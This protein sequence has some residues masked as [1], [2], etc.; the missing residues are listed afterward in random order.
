MCTVLWA[1]DDNAGVLA[2][3]GLFLSRHEFTVHRADDYRSAIDSLDKLVA[4]KGN[5]SDIALLVDV[6]LPHH[7]QGALSSRL[8]IRVAEGAALKGVRRICLLSVIPVEEI[9][10]ALEDLR[11]RFPDTSFT[12]IGKLD[13]LMANQLEALV[14]ALRR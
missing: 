6:I 2:P 10:S 12:F 8:G 11:A 1:D 14:R 13:L 9:E 5:C 3:I 7:A 4:M